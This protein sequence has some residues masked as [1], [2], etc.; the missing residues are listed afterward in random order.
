MRRNTTVGTV[1]AE[2]LAY[3]AGQD[4]ILDLALVEADC[5]GTAAHVRML[6]A[7]PVEPPVLKAAE[8]EAV[9]AELARIVEDSR[10]GKFKITLEDQDVHLA[11]ERRLTAKLGD[12]GKRVH[13]CRSRN[14]QVAVDL[15]LFG[16]TRLLDAM[17]AAA[18]LAG[19]LS[20]FARQHRKIPM[21]GRTHMQPAMPS[22]VGLWASAWAES[23]L[24]D[25]SL[26]M[27]AY[28]L[29][30]QCPLG[31][32]ASYGVP[33]PIDRQLTSDLLGFARPVS[34]VL[35][36]NQARGKLESVILSALS[37]AMLTLSR[38][39][40]DLILF[41]M[42]DF[43][44]FR[45][46]AEYTT[47]SSIM[48]QKRNPDVMELLRAK[49]AKVMAQASVTAEIV[50]A[51]PS[52]YNRD[53]QETK[54][55]FMRGFDLAISSLRVMTAVMSSLQVDAAACRRAF[56]PD[57]FATD[58]ALELVV[59][60]MPFRDAYRE[61]KAHLGD[62]KDRDPDAAI[63]AK[64]HLG[65]PAGLDFD[66]LDARIEEASRWV[67]DE[68]ADFEMH[69]DALLTGEPLSAPEGCAG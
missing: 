19:V 61:V 15:R 59:G 44:Y 24:D 36:A 35:H 63:A 20:A 18:A 57:V 53:L 7:M 11:V 56:T 21:V 62:L 55:P 3:T 65:A 30:D 27:A 28:D 46:P 43:G 25:F 33:L 12:L 5:M 49:A 50:R 39:A 2:V 48:P 58:R 66:G 22:S 42:P 45:L 14:D 1:D 8:V 29:N 51:A 10:A 68:R 47:G 37:Q 32:A 9:T 26:L 54:E 67:A 16:K 64:T 31:S 60:G 13:T 52:G 40:E 38:L 69:R 17:Q 6:A 4:R 41:S 34:N 23:L